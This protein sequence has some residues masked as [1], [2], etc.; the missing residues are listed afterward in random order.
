M[1]MK[2]FYLRNVTEGISISWPQVEMKNRKAYNIYRREASETEFKKM[3]S[4]NGHTFS[5][6][7]KNAKPGSIYVYYLSITEDDNR[8]GERGK[9]SS[10]RRIK[11]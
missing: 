5:Y 4:L 7:D 1:L 6:V 9:S 2:I 11:N 8:E 10:I 3:A